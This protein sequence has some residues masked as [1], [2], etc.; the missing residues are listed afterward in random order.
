MTTTLISRPAQ[1]WTL[2][3]K[4]TDTRNPDRRI[5]RTRMALWSALQ[6]LL[7]EHA[8]DAISVSMICKTADV[9]RSSFYGHFNSKMELL[10]FGFAAVLKDLRPMV[11]ATSAR[12]GELAT[13]H[14]LVNHISENK[15]FFR[16]ASQSKA[17]G[18]VFARFRAN[19]E[20]LLTEELTSKGSNSDAKM[21][22][23]VVGGIF[24]VVSKWIETG[25]IKTPSEIEE[26]VLALSKRVLHP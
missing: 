20:D 25:A 13:I 9:A 24:A 11:T 26:V 19:T 23:F 3:R 10:D 5:S 4:M 22:T 12:S 6:N 8:W 18:T 7:Q 17:D 2:G 15:A 14:W 21:V 1:N 16:R